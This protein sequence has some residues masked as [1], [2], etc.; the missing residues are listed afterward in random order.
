MHQRLYPHRSGRC[1]TLA[2]WPTIA[3][4]IGIC[5]GAG[6]GRVRLIQVGAPSTH[7]DGAVTVVLTPYVS[8]AGSFG[9]TSP[10]TPIA[11]HEGV[12]GEYAA[13]V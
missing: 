5:D 11:N 4:L 9:R 6:H 1:S 7:L 12:R 13:Y 10:F 3:I 2:R 8:D